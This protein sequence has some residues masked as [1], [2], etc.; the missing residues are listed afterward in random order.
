M[1]VTSWWSLPMW[2]ATCSRK[3]QLYPVNRCANVV[4]TLTLIN[5]RLHAKL[6]TFVW[7]TFLAAA[8]SELPSIPIEKV[9][10]GYL[11]PA[12]FASAARSAAVKLESS[13]PANACKLAW[14]YHIDIVTVTA[15][16]WPYSNHLSIK[17]NKIDN[18]S[19]LTKT[20]HSL[21]V[22]SY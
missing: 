15:L 22:A 14:N 4:N 20:I 10:I 11:M 7:C 5:Q 1:N 3:V 8:I 13:P 21:Q 12:K 18:L 19:T 17:I 6:N 9:W 16:W 2:A